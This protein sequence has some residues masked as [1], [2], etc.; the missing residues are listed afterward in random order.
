MVLSY[1]NDYLDLCGKDF[2]KEKWK[3]R[4]IKALFQWQVVL[5][6]EHIQLEHRT[7]CF[8]PHKYEEKVGGNEKITWL[9]LM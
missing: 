7:P 8:S 1:A 3:Q 2:M 6:S 9:G 4:L 5:H